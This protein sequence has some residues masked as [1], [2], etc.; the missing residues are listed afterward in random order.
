MDLRQLEYF[1]CVID[2]GSFS[3][4]AAVLNLAQ[5]S[6][7]RQIALL[8]SDLGQRLLNRTGRGV[9]PTEAG[10][11]LATHARSMLDT[12]KLA[13]NELR[14]LHAS[15]GGRVIVGMPPRVAL[16]LSVPLIQR[17]RERFPR[18]VITVLEGLSVPL[19]ESLIAGRLDLALLFDPLVSPQLE[20]Q[21]LMRER[22]LLVAPFGSKLPARV[23]VTSLTAY[24]MILPSAPNAIRSLLDAI[25]R[26]HHIELQVLAEVGAVN[27]VL[28]LVAKGIGCTVLPESALAM[29]KDGASL[30][31][32]PLCTPTVWNALML[33]TPLARPATRL[34]RETAQLLR[35]LDFRGPRYYK[36]A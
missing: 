34:M 27:T 31:F 25:L 4:A 6:L 20:Y 32:A 29:S 36:R 33:A 1:I 26:P 30:P 5:P 12:A 28:A 9:T 10:N 3:R 11:A 2:A 14:E 22:L 21:K 19:R 24:E 18:A 35:E 13:R 8:E 7:S 16:G 23:E 17:F 15:P